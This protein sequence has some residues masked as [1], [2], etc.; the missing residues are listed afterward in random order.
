MVAMKFSG[1]SYV[2]ELQAFNIF[3]NQEGV[4]PDTFLHQ[5]LLSSAHISTLKPIAKAG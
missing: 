2:K 4:V 1:K 5:R 3:H